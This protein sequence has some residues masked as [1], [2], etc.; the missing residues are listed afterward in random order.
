MN[1]YVLIWVA[2]ASLI[3]FAMYGM[4]KWNAKRGAF[5]ISENRLHL[6]ATLGGWPGA[7]IGRQVFR[8]KTQKQSFIWRFW[9]TGVLFVAWVGLVLFKVIPLSL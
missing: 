1:F 7:A 5:R 9:L 3:S 4:D 8:H 2:A 6:V